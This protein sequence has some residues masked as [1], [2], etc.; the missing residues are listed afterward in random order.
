MCDNPLGVVVG[1]PELTA[2]WE[3]GI[4]AAVGGLQDRLAADGTALDYSVESMTAVE[5]L[6]LELFPSPEDFF[7]ADDRPTVRALIAY[8][9][10]TLVHVGAG[11]WDWDAEPGF[12]ARAVPTLTD[13][14]VLEAIETDYWGWDDQPARPA[15]IPLAL[16]GP[17]MTVAPVSPLHLVLTVLTSR[18]TAEHPLQQEFSTWYQQ[19]AEPPAQGVPGVDVFGTPPPSP[20][21]DAWLS[22][23]RAEFGAWTARYPAAW[24]FRPESIETLTAEFARRIPSVEAMRQPENFDFVQGATWYLGE[25]LRRAAPSRWVFRDAENLIRVGLAFAEDPILVQYQIQSSDNTTNTTPYYLLM[26]GIKTDWAQPRKYY[27]NW[28]AHFSS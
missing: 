6:V 23:R 13:P 10:L 26:R 9:G 19:A 15:G 21:L 2:G 25:M 16:P 17:G 8:V 14:S 24:D 20:Q 1:N 5:S 12:A 3:D 4:A 18:G 27:T 7:S 11:R 28:S 22:D